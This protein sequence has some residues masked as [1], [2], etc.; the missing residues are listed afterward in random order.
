MLKVKK[1]QSTSDNMKRF[2][3]IIDPKGSGKPWKNFKQRND[4]IRTGSC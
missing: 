3:N 1:R 2:L 4:L